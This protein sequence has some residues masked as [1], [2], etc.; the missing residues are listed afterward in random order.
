MARLITQ[1][2]P[3]FLA[4]S[5][6]LALPAPSSSDLERRNWPDVTEFVSKVASLFPVNVAIKDVC[7]VLTAGE[8]FL[9]TTFGIP[10]TENDAC[11]DVT[12]M[13]ARGTCDPGNVGVLTGPFFF[14]ALEEKLQGSGRSLGVQGV[15][16]PA[17]V[18]GY[19]TGSPGNGENFAHAIR[20]VA[21][22]CPSTKIVLSGYSQGGMV[23]H[24]ATTNL[25]ASVMSRVSA[26]V[27]FGDP[28]AKRAVDNIDASKVHVICHEG[29]NICDNGPIIL[30]QHLTY[31]LDADSAADFVVSKV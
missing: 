4:A 21:T 8:L 24:G 28:Y 10:T 25:D 1:L 7:G 3:L 31:A 20:D 9:A 2:L 27:I 23:V 15:A 16:Y 14:K 6:V 19:L 11:G 5:Q 13:F 18:D 22:K 26:V 12:L 17:S 29:D 30:P